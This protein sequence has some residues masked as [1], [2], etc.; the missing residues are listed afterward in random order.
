MKLN[1]IVDKMGDV[2][3][4]F[5]SGSAKVEDGSELRGGVIVDPDKTVHE[6]EI[7]DTVLTQPSAK[8]FEEI[9]KIADEN[10]GLKPYMNKSGEK[11]GKR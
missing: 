2:V 5:G 1:I 4:A 7:Q 9:Q 3:G 8:V 11:A 10:L 6:I